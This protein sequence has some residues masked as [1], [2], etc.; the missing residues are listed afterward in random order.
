[1]IREIIKEMAPGALERVST[2]T[3]SVASAVAPSW[4]LSRM[5]SRMAISAYA[6]NGYIVPGSRRKSMKGVTA[7]AGSPDRDI[8]G[9]LSGIRAMQRDMFMNSPLAVSILR[10]HKIDV[11]NFGLQLQAVVDYET[12]GIKEEEAQRVER[13]AEFEFELWAESFFCDYNEQLVFGEMQSI[14]FLNMLLSGDCWMITPFDEP[15]DKDHP[16]GT[17]LKIIDA[18]LVRD[19][20]GSD[21]RERDILNGVERDEKGRVV[22]IHVW[23]AYECDG[24]SSRGRTEIAKS[25]RL[26]I[27]SAE[28]KRQVWHIADFERIDQRRGV[29]LLAAA[30]EP[31][32]QITRLSEA[33]LMNALVASFFSVFV[34]DSSGMGPLMGPA[35]NPSETLFGRGRYTPDGAQ[36]EEADLDN[37][38]DLEM[39]SGNINYLDEQT[40]ISIADPK[41]VD[42]GF[43]SFWGALGNQVSAAGG[44]PFEKAML[45]YTTSY[46]AA[47]AAANDS[48][49]QTGYYRQ[50]MERRMCKAAYQAVFEEAVYKGR[51][52]A[53]R[54]FDDA[55]YKK[56]WTGS[57]WTGVGMG[58]LDPL[59]D[60]KAVELDL[61][62]FTTTH[63]DEYQKRNGGRWDNSMRR[64]FRE[65]QLLDGYGLKKPETEPQPAPRQP[66]DESDKGNE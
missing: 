61:E 64:R 38:N 47:R 24:Y 44:I 41:K 42:T 19:P 14:A 16:Y 45:K 12:L 1:M 30:V 66:E 3:D 17:R 8:S 65:E 23:N 59:K 56:A 29:S 11:I 21:Y 62:N 25:K 36:V 51:I 4:G 18:D 58:S 53:P 46:T 57:H 33:Q 32:K 13:L 10:R 15:R 48:W 52:D 34:K 20:I 5:R 55:R 7:V 35:M 6:D 50:L 39:G 27:Y 37:G 9:K 22:A 49:R 54:Y 31:L 26:E 63:E 43:E 2:V 40:D 60:A 28:G